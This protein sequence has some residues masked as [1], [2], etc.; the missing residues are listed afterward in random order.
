MQINGFAM[1]I[2][3]TNGFNWHWKFFIA[4]FEQ[5]HHFTCE[6]SWGNS[7]EKFAMVIYTYTV[8]ITMEDFTVRNIVFQRTLMASTGTRSLL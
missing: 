6:F 5:F 1:V 4:L 2:R 8:P 7:V 3:Q